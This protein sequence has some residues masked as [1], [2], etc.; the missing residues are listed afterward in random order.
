MVVEEKNEE[1]GQ[2]R[3]VRREKVIECKVI[4]G[5]GGKDGGK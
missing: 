1:D 4:D 3:C 2:G 5:Q